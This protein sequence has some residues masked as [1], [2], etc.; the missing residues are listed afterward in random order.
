HTKLLSDQLREI[1]RKAELK[2]SADSPTLVKNID[3]TAMECEAIVNKCPERKPTPPRPT[4]SVWTQ[5]HERKKLLK[6]NVSVT[7]ESHIADATSGSLVDDD[8]LNVDWASIC[9]LM[10]DQ[11][12]VL[13]EE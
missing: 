9:N 7:L 8:E 6:D 3:E 13:R 1:N 12:N 10:K 4:P 2:L 5:I 11:R